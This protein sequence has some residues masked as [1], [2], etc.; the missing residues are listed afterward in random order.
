[1]LPHVPFRNL[2]GNLFSPNHLDK[3]SLC[4]LSVNKSGVSLMEWET[5][6]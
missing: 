1:M 4:T 5:Q 2:P 6:D 3:T